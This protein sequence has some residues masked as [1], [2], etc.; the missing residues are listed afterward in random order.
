M[1]DRLGDALRD[2]RARG[3][4]IR[5]VAVPWF[6]AQSW[7]RLLEVAADRA[8]LP[9]TFEGFLQ[10]AGERFDRHVANGHAL[11][12]ILIDVDELI[13]FCIA[14]GRPIDSRARAVF[15]A[16]LQARQEQHAG[17]A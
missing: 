4:K 12:K 15:A 8:D 3:F 10:R 16:Y 11:E 2:V 5:G 1:I 13:A 7:P 6:T 9:Q 14:L 17:H